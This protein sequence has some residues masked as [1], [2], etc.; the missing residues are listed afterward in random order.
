MNIDS[1]L[2]RIGWQGALDT[3]LTTLQRLH[4]LHSTNVPFE[5]LDIQL[6]RN[7]SLDLESLER[8]IVQN[9]RGGYCFEQN[10]LF[11]A[12]LRELGFDV[13]ACEARVKM[14]TRVIT[15]RT[16]MMLIVSLEGERYL[17][18]VGFGGEGLMHP[19]LIDAGEQQQFLWKYRLVRD[20]RF[21]VLQSERKTGWLDLYQF[22]PEHRHPVDFEVANWYTSTH[23]Q[24][25]FVLTLTAQLPTPEARF[26]LRNRTLVIDRVAVEETHEIGSRQ[27]LITILR[28]RFKLP[29]PPETSFRNPVF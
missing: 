7:I 24:S 10:T 15:P 22:V 8:K 20:D 5:N 27:E 9:S 28:E 16:H 21:Y 1:Y 13:I 19:V 14:G 4:F 23:P 6:G 2:R 17:V 3:G 12:V 11:Y 18:D 26:I 25:R 29:F